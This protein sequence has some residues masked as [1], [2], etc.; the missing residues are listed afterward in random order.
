MDVRDNSDFKGMTRKQ[1]ISMI[2]RQRND[3]IKCEG[4][5][6]QLKANDGLRKNME[7]DKLESQLSDALLEIDNQR[8]LKEAALI[9]FREFILL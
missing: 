4:L 8:S 6:S 1:L 3:L 9:T 5:K 7:I 2:N